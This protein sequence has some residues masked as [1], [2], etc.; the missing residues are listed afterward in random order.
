MNGTN[1][2]IVNWQCGCVVSEKA[3][4]EVKSDVCL[5]CSV[6]PFDSTHIIELYPDEELLKAYEER[7]SEAQAVT[8][9]ASKKL[10]IESNEAGI[11]KTSGRSYQIFI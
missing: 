1:R 2:F 4:S 7:V 6:T 10:A 3:I 8:K 5:G 9:K 11:P